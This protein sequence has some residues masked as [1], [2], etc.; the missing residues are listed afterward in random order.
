M[1]KIL[2]TLLTLL[3]T[4][5]SWA[6]TMYWNGGNSDWYDVANWYSDVGLTTPAGV[7]PTGSDDVILSAGVAPIVDL[8]N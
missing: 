1:S 4:Q 3:I 7:I 2:F 6:A 8:D 5:A